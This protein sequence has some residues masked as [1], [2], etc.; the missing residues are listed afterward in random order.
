MVVDD[1]I[2]LST[3]RFITLPMLL[4]WYQTP[5]LIY[6]KHVSTHDHIGDSFYEM[7]CKLFSLAFAEVAWVFTFGD[8]VIPIVNLRIINIIESH[9]RK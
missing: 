9:A 2:T 8:T 5:E 4:V 7:H 1:R 6:T 3:I